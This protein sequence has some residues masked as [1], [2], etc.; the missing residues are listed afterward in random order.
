MKKALITIL[1]IIFALSLFVACSNT[2]DENNSGSIDSNISEQSGEDSGDS[3]AEAKTGSIVLPL[4]ELELYV[5]QSAEIT[6]VYDKVEGTI[7]WQTSDQYVASV[8]QEGKITA[9]AIGE[10]TIS[11]FC[12]NASANIVVTVIKA[13]E[14]ASI[15][16]AADYVDIDRFEDLKLEPIIVDCAGPFIWISSDESVATV[17]NEGN[18]TPM[19]VGSCDVQIS[20]NGKGARIKIN[21]SEPDNLPTVEYGR[22]VINVL[23]NKTLSLDVVVKYNGN[24]VNSFDAT[25]SIADTSIATVDNAGVVKGITAGD[26]TMTV[27]VSYRGFNFST[28]TVPVSVKDDLD[29]RLSEKSVTVYLKD[30]PSHGFSTTKKVTVD[31]F[32]G[33]E[34]ITDPVIYWTSDNKN[35]ATVSADGTIKAVSEGK[36]VINLI[37]T[38]SVT[39]GLTGTAMINVSVEKTVVKLDPITVQIGSSDGTIPGESYLTLPDDFDGYPMSIS[40]DG[41][42]EKTLV[43]PGVVSVNELLAL[44]KASTKRYIDGE[45]LIVNSDEGVSYEFTLHAV[46]LIIKSVDDLNLMSSY[47]KAHTTS[48]VGYYVLD[49]DINGGSIGLLAE[50]CGGTSYTTNGFRGVFDGR[51]HVIRNVT[52]KENVFMSGLGENAIV[53]NLALIDP[54]QTVSS[55]RAAFSEIQGATIEN[56]II[57]SNNVSMSNFVDSSSTIKNVVFISRGGSGT[58]KMNQNLTGASNLTNAIYVANGYAAKD[59]FGGGTNVIKEAKAFNSVT[60]LFASLNRNDFIA[61]WDSAISYSN[62]TLKLD[63][64]SVL[65]DS[66][67]LGDRGF[68]MDFEYKENASSYTA[69][70]TLSELDTATKATYAGKVYD[71]S[72][73]DGTITVPAAFINSMLTDVN[74]GIFNAEFTTGSGIYSVKLSVC[75]KIISSVEDIRAARS[76]EEILEGYFIVGQDFDAS[77]SA[78]N[79]VSLLHWT[80]GYMS[81]KTNNLTYGFKGTFDGR[82]HIIRNLT[83]EGG[84]YAQMGGLFGSIQQ[85]AVIKDVAFINMECTGTSYKYLF[86]GESCCMRGRIENVVVTTQNSDRLFGWVRADQDSTVGSIENMVF[87]GGNYFAYFDRANDGEEG[88]RWGDTNKPSS[89][90]IIMQTNTAQVS[91]GASYGVYGATRY[92]TVSAMKTALNGSNAIASWNSPYITYSGG[93]IRFNG[94]SV[95]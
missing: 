70:Y 78:S 67:D 72:V 15:K 84:N 90:N 12:E 39:D 2:G 74:Y 36:T 48:H 28:K 60:E 89:S 76:T 94:V 55:V 4:S 21:V 23:K 27:N 31:V 41:V 88:N 25:Y 29:I 8:D 44:Y 35:I 30:D 40:A 14:G 9:V 24:A 62:E 71:V 85:G 38:S 11:V 64:R 18:V 81:D 59:T 22:D 53:R 92:A 82:G 1:S 93:Q 45:T 47:S 75:T 7:F 32:E 6:P 5:G 83:V 52:L 34:K 68:A 69:K 63:G 17:D 57:R 20:G 56:V 10:A 37:Y 66:V 3:Q 61:A 46:T 86:A 43:N 49:A 42:T 87:T 73:S 26:T 91:A 16:F 79:P 13:K 80:A 58:K 65:V 50:Y 51:G 95:I 33:S 77:A 19:G 54:I